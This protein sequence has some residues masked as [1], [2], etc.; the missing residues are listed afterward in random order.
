[1]RGTKVRGFLG[2]NLGRTPPPPSVGDYYRQAIPDDDRGIDFEISRMIDFVRHFEGHPIFI[3]LSRE[4]AVVANCKPRDQRCQAN[5]IYTWVCDNT[6]FVEDPVGIEALSTPIKMLNEIAAGPHS[7]AKGD[8]DDL[9][10]LLA[11][12]LGAIGIPPRFRFGGNKEEGIHHVWVQALVNQDRWVDMD[13]SLCWKM[14]R[15][16]KFQI[17]EIRDIFEI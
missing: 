15:S 12:M 17:Y 14:G 11:T 7:L 6:Y 9:S 4:I 16:H 13:P 1:V 2:K 5:A 3:D 8:C 10:T